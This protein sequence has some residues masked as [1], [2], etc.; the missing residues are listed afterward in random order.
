VQVK[1]PKA[2][3]GILPALFRAVNLAQA[4]HLYP[5]GSGNVTP[6]VECHVL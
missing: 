1:P 3:L 6:R 2:R 4:P 5:G